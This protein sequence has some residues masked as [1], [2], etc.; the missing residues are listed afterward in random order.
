MDNLNDLK[1]IWLTAETNSLPDSAAMKQAVKSF[2][3]KKL[4]KLILSV[5]FTIILIALMVWVIFVYRSKMITSRIGEIMII[6][7]GLILV[8]TNS[9]SINRFLKLQECSNKDYVKFLEHTR[10][11]QRFYQKRT[12]VVAMLFCFTGMMFYLYEAVSDSTTL[13]VTAYAVTIVYFLVLWLVVRPV[14]IRKDARKLDEEL[15]KIQNISNQLIN[16]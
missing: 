12:Q 10:L 6:I 3:N 16:L 9:N 14:V 15:K 11:R 7:A 8:V 13:L 4:F 5:A 1:A 2:R